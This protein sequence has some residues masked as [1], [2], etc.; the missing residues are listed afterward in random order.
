MVPVAKLMYIFILCFLFIYMFGWESMTQF[1]AGDYNMVTKIID[2]DGEDVPA[3]SFAVFV[4]NSS[5]QRS[6]FFYI[7]EVDICTCIILLLHF[8]KDSEM[9]T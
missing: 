6:I 9:P 2:S 8:S 4:K 5:F 1:I 7:N 3:P